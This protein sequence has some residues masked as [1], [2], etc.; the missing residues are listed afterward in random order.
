[1]EE[2]IQSDTTQVEI[3][4]FSTR[5]VNLLTSPGELYGEVAAAPVQSSSWLIPYL[6]LIAVF[7]LMMY[8]ITNN[9]TLY[10]QALEPQRR[11]LQKGVAE[12]S[13]TQADADRARE[14]TAN[15]GMFMAFGI[16]GGVFFVSVVMFGAPLVLWLASKSAFGFRGGYKKIL[17]VY[18]LASIIGIVG[19]LVT[20]IMMNLMDSM[21][22]QPSG[23]FLI[24]DSYDMENFGHNFLASMNVFS[25]WQVAVSGI[26]LAAVSGKRS[27]L[28]MMLAFGLWMIYV[29][30]A[31]LLGWG[32]R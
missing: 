13:M 27:S 32:A 18:G 10:D 25:I 9:P 3:S 5:A 14:F 19:T 17:E 26:G 2:N 1:M 11:A 20:L 21:Y 16:L 7:G 30:C 24:R 29:V 22:A 4:S 31:S 12:G 15:K 28:G 23:A 8:A 6:L